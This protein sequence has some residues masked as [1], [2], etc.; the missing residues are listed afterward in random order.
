M[1]RLT[2]DHEHWSQL[3]LCY[4]HQWFISSMF[5]PTSIFSQDSTCSSSRWKHGISRRLATWICSSYV[6]VLL[7]GFAL[8]FHSFWKYTQRGEVRA[9]GELL[10]VKSRYSVTWWNNNN[11]FRHFDNF[12]FSP[13]GFIIQALWFCLVRHTIHIWVNT[14]LIVQQFAAN[15]VKLRE[16]NRQVK[17]TITSAALLH[18]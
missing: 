18:K 9:E 3:G 13:K 11:R 12:L 15:F 16:I 10:L 5:F 1:N 7:Y 2:P 8:F 14:I 4:Q 17:I 6:V